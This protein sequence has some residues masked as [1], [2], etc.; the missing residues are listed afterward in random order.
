MDN[1]V[2]RQL[3]KLIAT[4][5]GLG[6]ALGEFKA[7]VKAE[8]NRIEDVIHGRLN[9]HGERLATL[10]KDKAQAAGA[11]SASRTILGAV[12]AFVGAVAGALAAMFGYR[13]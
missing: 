2:E 5:E 4:T 7:E 3:G 1:G 11:V 12:W 6:K 10:E 8:L 13:G 9:N